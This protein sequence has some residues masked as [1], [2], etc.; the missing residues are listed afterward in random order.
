MAHEPATS[1]T[2]LEIYSKSIKISRMEVTAI[3]SIFTR[4]CFPLQFD[5]V[6]FWGYASC[7]NRK[8]R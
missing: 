5:A 1:M 7:L 6:S 3:L 4:K 2:P 8:V